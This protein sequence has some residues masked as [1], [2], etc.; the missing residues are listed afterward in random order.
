MCAMLHLDPANVPAYLRQRGWLASGQACRVE[1]LSG[2]VSNVVLRVQMLPDGPAIVL[3]QAL[4]QLR[5]AQVWECPVERIWREVQVLRWCQ[6]LLDDAA[7]ARPASPATQ[8]APWPADRPLRCQVP[9]LLWED[10]AN[11]LYAMS[12]AS[13]EARTC[14]QKLLAGELADASHVLAAAGSLLGRLH[15]RSWQH[16]ALAADLA[17]RQFFWMLRV[18]PYYRRVQEVHPDRAEPLDALIASLQA[19]RLCLVHGDYSPKNLLVAPQALWLI[20][21]EVGHFGDP[22]FDVGFFLTHLALKAL[23][24]GPA[25]ASRLALVDRFW[26]AY[27]AE[28][29][30]CAGSAA[31]EALQP[32]A[33]DHL[34]G[35]MLA[36]VDGKS[37]VDYLT[38][39]E[40]QI[41]RRLARE[42]LVDRPADLAATCQRLQQAAAA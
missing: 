37:P 29:A 27:V 39:R 13:P 10:R 4:P 11:Y 1:E 20:D 25:A 34:A 41:V 28:L 16:A 3:K 24:A 32:R 2:G 30:P 38:P 31:I 35:C 42:W 22:A 17:D 19:H 12:A 18:D 21:F 26:Q 15:A 8:P 40:Q 6:R 36:R 7:E 14:K 5:V 9:E 33:L 23:H